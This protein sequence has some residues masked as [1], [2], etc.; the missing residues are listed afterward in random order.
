[1]HSGD[2][3]DVIILTEVKR[4]MLKRN[5]KKFR[6]R[7]PSYLM[8]KSGHITIVLVTIVLLEIHSVGFLGEDSI[9]ILKIYLVVISFLDFSV[10]V[11]AD[12][13]NEGAPTSLYVIASIWQL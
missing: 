11:V 4:L 13:E 8:V 6:R 10:E 5:S 3:L 2:W 12:H 9:S 7:M 1:M